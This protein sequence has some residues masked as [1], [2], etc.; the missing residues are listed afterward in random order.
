MSL[1]SASPSQSSQLAS[2]F[3][4]GGGWRFFLG[5]GGAEGDVSEEEWVD[6]GARRTGSMGAESQEEVGER[7]GTAEEGG[8]GSGGK[9]R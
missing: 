9:V 1:R 7:M 4:G 8:A 5:G 6:R 2:E 3:N